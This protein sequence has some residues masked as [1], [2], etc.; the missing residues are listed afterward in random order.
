[1]ED[2]LGKLRSLNRRI[3]NHSRLLARLPSNKRTATGK[4]GHDGEDVQGVTKI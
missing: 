1:M 3:T 4:R 2:F